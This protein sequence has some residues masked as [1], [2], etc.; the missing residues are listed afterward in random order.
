MAVDGQL[1]DE[2][3]EPFV[4]VARV[5]V[6]RVVLLLVDEGFIGDVEYSI[7]YSIPKLI[8]ALP[9]RLLAHNPSLLIPLLEALH[10]PLHLPA[11]PLQHLLLTPYGCLLV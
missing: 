5:E 1:I 6:F 8:P 2:E 10:L 9:L 7:K 11:Q 4:P 3:L